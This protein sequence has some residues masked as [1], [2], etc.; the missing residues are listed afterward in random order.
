MNVAEKYQ[1][2][3]GLE[4]LPLHNFM[5]CLTK[6]EYQLLL[7]SGT[8]DD[9]ILV[10][11]WN[12]LFAEYAEKMQSATYSKVVSIYQEL[13]RLQAR[14]MIVSNSLLILAYRY[15][16]EIAAQLTKLGYTLTYDSSNMTAYEK[17]LQI[18]ARKA[19]SIT[20]LILQKQEELEMLRKKSGEN[21][22]TYE[23]F[24]QSVIVVSRFMG[25]KIDVKATT[26]AEWIAM[27]QQY[28]RFVMTQ[29]QL[30]KKDNGGRKN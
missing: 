10:K 4:E 23:K 20:I 24:L 2:Y 19:K 15:D 26:V 30:A 7:K 5:L 17:Q 9:D 27:Q 1:L 28:E 12:E 6:A 25:Y 3:Q 14:A 22:A 8:A 21:A 18:I 16:K 11:Y 29:E 13:V